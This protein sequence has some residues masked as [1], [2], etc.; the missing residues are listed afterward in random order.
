MSAVTHYNPLQLKTFLRN[1][2]KQKCYLS[3]TSKYGS[4]VLGHL[5][6]GCRDRAY[7]GVVNTAQ[8]ASQYALFNETVALTKQW[9]ET[10]HPELAISIDQDNKAN[11]SFNIYSIIAS[12]FGLA[13]AVSSDFHLLNLAKLIHQMQ[14]M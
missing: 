14:R 7:Q 11:V 10:N 1:E 3:I 4:E 9:F 6:I 5:Y 8:K 13:K 12:N 2:I